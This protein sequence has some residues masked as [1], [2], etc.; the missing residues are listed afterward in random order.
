[1]QKKVGNNGT[2]EDF[3]C[4][5]K[6]NL[7]MSP[8]NTK[9][10]YISLHNVYTPECI[11]K[12]AEIGMIKYVNLIDGDSSGDFE[13]NHDLLKTMR[14]IPSINPTHDR[15]MSPVE[16]YTFVQ[17]RSMQNVENLLY[18]PGANKYICIYIL[19]K[20]MRIRVLL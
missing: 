18:S 2:A 7:K 9:H 16:G 8:N 4:R 19:V 13:T 10:C 11:L 1:M 14:H 5:K 6:G 17:L 12:L 3:Q 20:W 15:K